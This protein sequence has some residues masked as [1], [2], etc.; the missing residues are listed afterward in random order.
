M[1]VQNFA[2]MDDETLLQE[3]AELR[4][5]HL[6]VGDPRVPFDS[7]EWG[8]AARQEIYDGLH[9]DLMAALRE[10]HARGLDTWNVIYPDTPHS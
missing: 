9:A 2:A 7:H 1:V 4:K 10:A 3:L 5:Y 6:E 8:G